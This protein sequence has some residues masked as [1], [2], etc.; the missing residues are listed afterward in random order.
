MAQR[1]EKGGFWAENNHLFLR[2]LWDGIAFTCDKTLLRRKRKREGREGKHKFL[3][4]AGQWSIAIFP[5]TSMWLL[6]TGNCPNHHNILSRIKTHKTRDQGGV[7]LLIGVL[8]EQRHL[9]PTTRVPE[10]ART[11]SYMYSYR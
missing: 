4:E 9:V 2:R 3:F 8:A 5:S 7:G 10:C 11:Y 6:K 1:G